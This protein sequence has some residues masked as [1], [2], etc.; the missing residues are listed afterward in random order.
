MY[1]K[2]N[3]DNNFLMLS[4]KQIDDTWVD[5]NE[6]A[7]D[8]SGNL[9]EYYIDNLTPNIHLNEKELRFRKKI[10]FDQSLRELQVSYQGVSY[11]INVETQNRL[12]MALARDDSTRD[13]YLHDTHHN[14]VKLDKSQRRGL[15]DEIHNQENILLFI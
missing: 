8:S 14:I 2:I 12:L 1:G 5:S 13:V 9:Y 4:E 10:K 7:K 11:D 6:F 15:V 3:I